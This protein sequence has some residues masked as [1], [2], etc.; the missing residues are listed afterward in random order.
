[1]NNNFGDQS[2]L[3]ADVQQKSRG[4]INQFERNGLCDQQGL[5]ILQQ[6]GGFKYFIA[7]QN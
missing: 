1:M 5:S 2:C 4:R 3:C 7:M 6:F